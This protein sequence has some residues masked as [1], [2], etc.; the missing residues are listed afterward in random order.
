MD[1]LDSASTKAYKCTLPPLLTPQTLHT[2][3]QK[4]DVPAPSRSSELFSDNP[5]DCSCSSLADLIVQMKTH[6][7]LKNR[8]NEASFAKAS[9][10]T[11]PLVSIQT[12]CQLIEDF[13]ARV[14]GSFPTEFKQPMFNFAQSRIP[15]WRS[16]FS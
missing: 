7:I 15:D 1:R 4:M 5:A 16:W 9:R 10:K 13:L 11:P 3:N 14:T 8:T 2:S 12:I 6:W